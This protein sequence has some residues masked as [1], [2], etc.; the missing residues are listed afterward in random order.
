MEFMTC[1]CFLNNIDVNVDEILELWSKYEV[2]YVYLNQFLELLTPIGITMRSHCNILICL[3][4]YSP[5]FRGSSGVPEIFF[6]CQVRSVK[7][8]S[9]IL[10]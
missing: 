2:I 8:E 6:L 1:S 7:C 9:F 10:R 5:M 4:K 3:A